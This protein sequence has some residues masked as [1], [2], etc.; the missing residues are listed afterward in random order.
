MSRLKREMAVL[1]QQLDIEK[2]VLEAEKRKNA[3]LTEQLK[4]KIT[5]FEDNRH[6]CPS[7]HTHVPTKGSVNEQFPSSWSQDHTYDS[8]PTKSGNTNTRVNVYDSLRAGSATA[9]IDG[10]Q[11]QLKLRD[12]DNI[13]LQANIS[14]LERVKESMTNELMKLTIRNEEL[15]S[16]IACLTENAS[17]H[18]DLQQKY[19][20]LLQMYGEVSEEAEELKLDLLDVKDMYKAQIDE[21]MKRKH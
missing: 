1:E 9:V 19:N 16:T 14:K 20:A 12:G 8:I 18:E 4:E 17:Q 2:T 6:S 3:V 7:P 11:S 13:Q 15:E 21:L 5:S 10:L